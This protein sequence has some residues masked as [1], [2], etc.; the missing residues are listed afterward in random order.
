MIMRHGSVV[1]MGATDRVFGNPLHPYTKTLVTSV[2]QLHKKWRDVEVE[3]AAA[4]APLEAKRP[5]A[6][7]PGRLV[8]VE[9]DHFV[10]VS[11]EEGEAAA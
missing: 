1:E 9:D 6:G 5:V 11:G 8:E 3:L 10:A 7:G 2:P 4:A